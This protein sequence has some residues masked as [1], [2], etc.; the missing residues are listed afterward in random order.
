MKNELKEIVLELKNVLDRLECLVYSD[1]S[2]YVMSDEDYRHIVDYSEI[3]DDDGYS[4]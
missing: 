3:D 2:R 1:T 4:D